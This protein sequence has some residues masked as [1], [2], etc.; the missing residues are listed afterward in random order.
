[1][2]KTCAGCEQRKLITDFYKSRTFKDGLSRFCKICT[3]QR[4]QVAHEANRR[5]L[6]R[7]YGNECACC[8]ESRYEFLAIDHVHNDG[9]AERKIRRGQSS[10][11]YLLKLGYCKRYQILCHNC[12]LAKGFYGECPHEKMR[13]DVLIESRT[14]PQQGP[15]FSEIESAELI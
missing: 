3:R 11:R 6:L 12:N 9:A 5:K 1:M 13:K 14:A 8:F 7:L 15:S 2:I 10:L 4:S